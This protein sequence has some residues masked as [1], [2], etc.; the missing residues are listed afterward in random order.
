MAN[1][2]L[3]PYWSNAH[4]DTLVADSL[5]PESERDITPWRLW[6]ALKDEAIAL[7]TGALY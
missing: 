5:E 4:T 6:K 7:I 1:C 2:C 3:P